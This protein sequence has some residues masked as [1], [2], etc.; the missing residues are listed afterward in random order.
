MAGVWTLSNDSHCLMTPFVSM[1]WSQESSSRGKSLRVFCKVYRNRGKGW[2]ALR[3]PGSLGGHWTKVRETTIVRPL[4]RYAFLCW[5]LGQSL[6]PHSIIPR[7]RQG[8]RPSSLGLRQTHGF[9]TLASAHQC[10]W[11]R[12]LPLSLEFA[13]Q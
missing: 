11:G 10:D 9:S 7:F 2:S 6:H 4:L 1:A 3:W 8:L 12:K 5:S 13:H